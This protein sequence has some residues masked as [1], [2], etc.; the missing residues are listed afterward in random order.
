M[1]SIAAI[2][3][4]ILGPE[5]PYLE[6]GMLV[7]DAQYQRQARRV[8]EAHEELQAELCQRQVQAAAGRRLRHAAG[9]QVLRHRD[10]RQLPHLLCNK[11]WFA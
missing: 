1:S 10:R 3:F 5:N 8:Q 11:I 2:E 7:E 9:A 6:G 4:Q